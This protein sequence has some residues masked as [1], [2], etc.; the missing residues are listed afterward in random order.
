MD[1]RKFVTELRAFVA[2]FHDPRAW[3]LIALCAGIVMLID[4]VMVKTVLVW[5]LQAGVFLGLA[6]IGSRFVFPQIDLLDHVT[7][8]RQGNTAAGLVVLTV[9]LIWLGIMLSLAIFGRA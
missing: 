8:A 4:P 3:T 2:P 9:G 7:Q 5:V 1:F 6:I